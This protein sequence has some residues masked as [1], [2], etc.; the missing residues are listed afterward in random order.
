MATCA[1]ALKDKRSLARHVGK[2]LTARYGK[3]TH[4]SPTLVKVTMRR[5]NYPDAWDCW[6]LSLFTDRNDFTA[7]HDSLGELC[8]YAT[9]NSE[10]LNAVSSDSLLDFVSGD[11]SIGDFLPDSG[12]DV[13]DF[14]GHDS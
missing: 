2:H 4:Y 1:I 10:M 13:S 11:W 14:S 9:M 7:Y 5:L 8:N 6:A 12:L 3:R